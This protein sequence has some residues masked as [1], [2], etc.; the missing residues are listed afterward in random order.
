MTSPVE[1][2]PTEGTV[3][4][5]ETLRSRCL[6]HRIRRDGGVGLS[7]FLRQ[8]MLAWA[9]TVRA[10]PNRLPKPPVPRDSS[11]IP[12]TLRAGIIDVM[13]AMVTSVSRSNHTGAPSS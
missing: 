10:E 9:R 3:T 4:A 5:Y 11:P 12:A 13:V 2:T 7:V 1:A 6:D 8:G